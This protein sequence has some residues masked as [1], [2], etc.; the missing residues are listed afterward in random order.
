MA[1]PRAR[2]AVMTC[3]ENISIVVVLVLKET[4]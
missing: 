2:R 1:E 4:M 3:L